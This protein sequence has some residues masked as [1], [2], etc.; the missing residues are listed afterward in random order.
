MR[1]PGQLASLIQARLAAGVKPQT[2]DLGS[3]VPRLLA[4]F[5]ALSDQPWTMRRPSRRGGRHE[6]GWPPKLSRLSWPFSSR[7]MFS[8]CL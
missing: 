6:A 4:R 8:R 7:P 3:D 1:G 5:L 2:Y